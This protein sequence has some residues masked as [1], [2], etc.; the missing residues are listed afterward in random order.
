MKGEKGEDFLDQETHMNIVRYDRSYRS[1]AHNFISNLPE[2]L[3]LMETSQKAEMDFK[4]KQAKN[5]VDLKQLCR[6][7]FAPFR[8]GGFRL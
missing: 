7:F 4:H 8:R 6:N 5:V 2:N 3:K 1:R